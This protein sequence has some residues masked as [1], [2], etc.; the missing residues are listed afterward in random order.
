MKAIGGVIIT[1]KLRWHGH[2]ERKGDADWVKSC[3]NLVA[4]GTVHFGRPKKTC[5]NMVSANTGIDIHV[6]KTL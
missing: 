5:Q 6:E 4:E 3:S 1:G 2:V